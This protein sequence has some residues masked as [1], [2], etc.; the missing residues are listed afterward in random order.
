MGH[1]IG[2]GPPPESMD[3]AAA[4]GLVV[5]GTPD[6]HINRTKEYLNIKLRVGLS[7]WA[8]GV[9][10]MVRKADTAVDPSTNGEFTVHIAA[11][12]NLSMFLWDESGN[13]TTFSF[14]VTGFAADSVHDIEVIWYSNYLGSGDYLARCFVDGLKFGSDKTGTTFLIQN[15]KVSTLRFGHATSVTTTSDINIQR[16]AMYG[17]NG[18]MA[19]WTPDLYAADELVAS[20]HLGNE[21]V[22]DITG[23]WVPGPRTEV[24]PRAQSITISE[25]IEER[26]QA[27]F[28]VD[29]AA[30]PTILAPGEETLPFGLIGEGV[31][32]TQV[33]Y[34]V[35]RLL[36]DTNVQI[37]YAHSN[38]LDPYVSLASMGDITST[39]MWSLA[40]VDGY[41]VFKWIETGPTTRTAT[42]TVALSADFNN[43]R[44]SLWVALDVDNGS[45]QWTV[46]FYTSTTG[47]DG[48][49][50][51]LDVVVGTTG[52][53]DV[54]SASTKVWV[55]R[56]NGTASGVGIHGKVYEFRLASDTVEVARLSPAAYDPDIHGVGWEVNLGGVTLPPTEFPLSSVGMPVVIN[57]DGDRLFSGYVDSIKQSRRGHGPDGGLQFDVRVAD[58]HYLVDKRLVGARYKNV[59]AGGIV[60]DVIS[61]VFGGPS[62]NPLGILEPEGV[63]PVARSGWA[64]GALPDDIP[65][66]QA[67]YLGYDDNPAAVWHTSLTEAKPNS[68][69]LHYQL[70]KANL[71]E[72]PIDSTEYALVFWG[73]TSTG[74][75]RGS[76]V[77]L[78]RSAAQTFTLTWYY[79]DAADVWQ[80][81]V[82][83]ATDITS[84]PVVDD[85]QWFLVSW[86]AGSPTKGVG[87][88]EGGTGDT[89]D[90]NSGAWNSLI[91]VTAIGPDT[92]WTLK[93]APMGFGTPHDMFEVGRMRLYE[94]SFWN[95]TLSPLGPLKFIDHTFFN[96]VTEW[97][98]SNGIVDSYGVRWYTG[99][100]KPN[101]IRGGDRSG[102]LPSFHHL[103]PRLDEVVLNYVPVSS[104][105]DALAEAAGF[106]WFVD[107]YKA[108]HFRPRG[109]QPAP[110]TV[111]GYQA[112]KVQVSTSNTRYRNSQVIRGAKG[113]TDL[114]EETFVGDGE[115]KAFNTS[116]PVLFEPII[117][118]D[119]AVQTVGF[120]GIDD[121][122]TD[123]AWDFESNEISQN[124]DDTALT[125]S[126]V[127]R[128]SYQGQFR[129]LVAGT[130]PAEV[131]R[132]KVIEGGTG[133]VEVV[134]D[135]KLVKTQEVALERW[136]ALLNKF[137]VRAITVKF[138]IRVAGLHAGQLV[139]LDF[140]SHGIYGSYLIQRVTRSAIGGPNYVWSIEAVGGP[141]DKSWESF[142][143]DL[144][145]PSN[146]IREGVSGDAEFQFATLDNQVW[147]WRERVSVR[148]T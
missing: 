33:A 67:M 77:T 4:D 80:S 99:T 52:T 43:R 7:D 3:F 97:P 30:N 128:V 71:S 20:D 14:G 26:S 105:F 9:L 44:N 102:D 41:P 76:M 125:S 53:T 38:L 100:E 79:K 15:P 64:K 57:H 94:A 17:D 62:L 107:R 8:D 16:L 81:E 147:G 55:G 28:A 58:N 50:T 31:M 13:R 106:T 85:E 137:G 148:I 96:D 54:Q 104:A 73:D 86:S 65:V 70:F 45:G 36:G 87:W 11:A 40:L 66:E 1:L 110:F 92:G 131:S 143:L 49:W 139:F 88:S 95:H 142:F 91:S 34:S 116:Y 129:L 24:L 51:L 22:T 141:S 114:Q 18:P 63:A 127:L 136:A 140:A 29:Q 103:G 6:A 59:P 145:K 48:P 123:F 25:R 83:A 42:S 5:V 37:E 144:I 109:S 2:I 12:G 130:D 98:D 46:S 47:L 133:L 89:Q 75:G 135:N 113:V 84:T 126:E 21:W 146:D 19:F 117:T 121:D 69:N 119:D 61:G 32:R 35:L 78:A 132:N 27:Q 90:P 10:H 118:V 111:D 82:S 138:D 93:F 134:E 56:E 112:E 68:S 122:D 124:K 115:R 101:G 72:W 39:G 108:V 60:A 23:V 74:P 120:R